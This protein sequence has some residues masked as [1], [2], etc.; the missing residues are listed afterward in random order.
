MFLRRVGLLNSRDL[1][2]PEAT[3]LFEAFCTCLL[4]LLYFLP[5]SILLLWVNRYASFLPVVDH[6]F[7]PEN[8]AH[9]VAVAF[10]QF[11]TTL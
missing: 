1:E 3:V 2:P 9:R 5:I 11:L 8:V 10:P 4:E 6:V 7:Q